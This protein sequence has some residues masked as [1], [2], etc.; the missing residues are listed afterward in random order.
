MANPR[1]DVLARWFAVVCFAFAGVAL[2]APEEA[3]L[4][5]DEG[6]PTCARSLQVEMRCLVGEVSRRDEIYPSRKVEKASQARAFKRAPTEAVVH[7]RWQGTPSGLDDYLARNRTTGLV[8]LKGDTILAERYQYQRTP[9]HR[10]TS[11]SMAKTVV[12]MLVGFAVADGS[13]RSLDDRADR[14]VAALA[15][16]PYGETPIRHLLTMS[17]GV[18]FIENYSGSD[19]VFTL[20]R[21]TLLQESEGGTT[22]VHPFNTREAPAGERFRY[23]SGDTQ[24]LGLVLRA[25]TGKPLADYLSQKLWQPMGAEADATWIVDKGGFELGF[26]G[27]NATVRDYARL[28]MLLANDGKLDG[29]QI[30]PAGWVRAATTPSAPQFA[31]GKIRNLAGSGYSINGYGYQT[32]LMPGK[33]GH[34]MLRGV[35][36]QAIFVDP[37]SKL[38]LVH[39]AAEGI[40]GGAG[41][42]MALWYGIV[43]EFGKR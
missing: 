6:Y 37:G 28:G 42:L 23:A 40:G 8:I 7:Y 3:A 11:M 14:Y 12:A 21:L 30:I 35:R 19:D 31:P 15:D 25:A 43:K 9:A 27:L 39:T 22:T 36:N 29:R 1:T 41:E 32:W 20:A 17:A 26:S 13:I 16:T 33:E 24:V 2:P 10:M 18:R 38:V 4:G 5:R 34:F